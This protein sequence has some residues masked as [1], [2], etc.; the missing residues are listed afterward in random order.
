MSWI[1]QTVTKDT[2]KAA[3][4]GPLKVAAIYGIVAWGAAACARP[5]TPAVSPAPIPAPRPV[6]NVPAAPLIAVTRAPVPP[7]NPKLPPV[8]E[9]NGEL[10][11]KVVYPPANALVSSKDSN[12]IFGSVGNG[13]AGL[14]INGTLVPV[15]PNGAF[16]GWVP[17]PP[18]KTP[19]YELVAYTATDT[20]RYV[21]PVRTRTSHPPKV[22]PPEKV[23]PI[24]PAR[25]AVLRNDSLE[26]FVAD[27]DRVIIGRPTPTG[28]YKW[29]LFPGTVV[30]MTGRLGNKVRVQL[31]AGREIWVDSSDVKPMR[32]T[33]NVV[34]EQIEI[35]NATLNPK[36][37]W[38]DF[39]VPV[40]QPPA[41]VVEEP[42][43][44]TIT[45]IFYNATTD[46]DE[47]LWTSPDPDPYLTN[48]K[49]NRTKNR[50]TYTFT[51]SRPVFGYLAMYKDGAMTFRM[52]RP[53][54]VSRSEP[55]RGLTIAIDPGHPPAG[56]TGPTGLYEAIPNLAV[57][58]R[59]RALLVEKGAEVIMTR[60][61][62]KAV[63]LGDRPI[64]ARRMNAHALVSIHL[65]ALP[66]GMN[67]FRHNGTGTY[68][69]HTHSKRFAT[70][71]QRALLPQLGLRDLGV[72]RENLA[73]VRPTW[74]P[75]VLTEGAFIIMPD[76]EAALRTSEY[77]NA[78]ALGIV[79]G[80][81]AFF[82]IYSR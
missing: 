15:W 60:T 75:S 43:E 27:T 6:P 4:L 77:Q 61:S 26:R 34:S 55:L 64:L 40:G 79:N 82:S 10:K 22:T 35:K 30:K 1:T 56:A 51:F 58:E 20:V 54:L 29:F 37:D 70:L 7:A 72:F 73:L 76:Q 17:N 63:A 33:A 65:N 42:D 62:N 36:D 39:R 18:G 81:E 45:L 12:F 78:Y 47:P 3:T 71:M 50:T 23:T 38:I 24:S 21:H 9:V 66:D 11:I 44:F 53:P 68:Y 31:D 69:F 80:L 13:T 28:T 49:V 52:R 59:V 48:T 16:M 19:E 2:L 25:V 57:A 8:P 5:I 32:T 67:P 46:P 14:T 74:M 41:Y